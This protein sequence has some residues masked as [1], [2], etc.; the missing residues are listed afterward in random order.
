M[1]ID[2]QTRE[3]YVA[4]KHKA[5]SVDLRKNLE[6]FPLSWILGLENRKYRQG[7]R[8]SSNFLV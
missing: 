3:A 8:N 7:S 6:S 5:D 2:A 1:P 4:D